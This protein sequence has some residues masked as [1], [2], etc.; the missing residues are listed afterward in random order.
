MPGFG[1]SRAGQRRRRLQMNCVPVLLDVLETRVLLSS[2]VPSN[3]VPAA[4][5]DVTHVQHAKAG[6][7]SSS[8]HF[9]AHDVASD[10][11]YTPAQIRTAYGFNDVSFGSTPADG[12]GQT[13][14]IIDA[15][16]DP[17]IKSDLAA[18]DSQLKIAAPPS[19]S[20][21]N[22]TGGSSLPV[23]DPKQGWEAET[24]LDV[25][26][27]HAIAPGANIVL[28][29]ASS[30]SDT[31]LFAAV[32]YARN[33]ASVSVISMSWGT[34]DNAADA[35]YDQQLS[36][37]YLVTP[38][39][40][41]GITFVASSGDDGH[42]NFPAES[43]NVLAVGGTDLYLNSSNGISRETAWTPQTDSSGNVW[44]G[45]GG[46]SQ[47]FAGR[48]VPDVAYNAGVAMAVY[49]TFGSDHGWVGVGGTSAGAPQWAALVAIADQGRAAAKL[50]SLNGAS[51][52]LTALYAAPSSDFRDITSGSTQFQS[53]SAG[54][55]LATGLGTPVANQ[56]ISYLASYGGSTTTT[57]QTA[58]TTPTG[59]KA[60]VNPD[61]SVVLTWSGVTHATG[62]RIL[63]VNGSKT[64]SL[65]TISA[66]STSAK[67]TGLTAGS[68]ATFEVEAFNSTSVAHSNSV[69]VKIPAATTLAAPVVTATALSTTTA[70]L[71]W[72]AVAGA[73]GYAIYLDSGGKLTFLG[74]VNAKSTS[75]TVQ[76]L[77]ANTTYQFVVAAYAGNVSSAS[78]A[79]SVTTPPYQEVIPP[80]WWG[81]GWSGW[82]SW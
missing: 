61:N 19:F 56:V 57:K 33:L 60:T 59:V 26:W 67:I 74:T 35:A 63:E 46:V 31:D 16:N 77:T 13:I 28:V 52:T 24:A 8:H 21:V 30:D 4:H 42:P 45:S 34:D 37:Q 54:Y 7:F 14:A 23:S 51:Q 73:Q 66:T 53:A 6:E 69:T 44:S 81:W 40:H 75:V 18:F 29:E 50:T 80:P 64:T 11:G 27:A 2:S 5:P 1:W 10:A 49:D 68:T 38:A 15:Y 72:N 47:E 58:V 82:W 79:V 25:E 65:G 78:I 22:Q 20:V 39:G 41:Q 36:A 32:N 76:G 3:S 62:I 55:D 71:S 17:N 43:P 12:R 9:V 48:K 70:S